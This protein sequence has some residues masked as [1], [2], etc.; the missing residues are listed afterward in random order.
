MPL[1]NL[2][3]LLMVD[4]CACYL[5]NIERS[6]HVAVALVLGAP[7]ALCAARL[8]Q[9]QFYRMSPFD[10]AVFIAATIGIAVVTVISAWVPARR[11][12]SVDP[13]AALRCE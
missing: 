13:M 2:I 11:A 7:I 10:P 8:V 4:W 9:A 5:L 12:A 1:S 3:V 6:G